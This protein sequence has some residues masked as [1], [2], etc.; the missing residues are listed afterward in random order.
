MVDTLS[1]K[2]KIFIVTGI[3]V[4]IHLIIFFPVIRFNDNRIPLLAFERLVSGDVY[5]ARV[6]GNHILE[7][8][9]GILELRSLSRVLVVNNTIVDIGIENFITGRATHNFSI[10]GITMPQNI[11]IGL[12]TNHQIASLGLYDQEI[13]LSHIP[14]DVR[15]FSLIPPRTSANIVIDFLAD[16]YI[17]LADSTEIQFVPS[18]I[19]APRFLRGLYIYDDAEKWRIVGR[20][21]VR[22]PEEAYFTMYRSITFRRNWGEFIEGELFE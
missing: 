13:I 1:K 9:H 11:G 20:T 14:L 2:K 6:L 19:G 3:I 22:L 18:L 16:G 17:T 4:I 12:V 21:A 5:M 10:N 7:T 15:V 8:E